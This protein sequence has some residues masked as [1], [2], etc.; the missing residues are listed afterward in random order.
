[1]KIVAVVFFLLVL[2][3]FI[4]TEKKKDS[5]PPT[6]AFLYAKELKLT[7]NYFTESSIPVK[8]NTGC[9]ERY[10]FDTM[11]LLSKNMV[12]YTDSDSL[13]IMKINYQLVFCKIDHAETIGKQVTIHFSGNGYKIIFTSKEVKK[14]RDGLFIRSGILEISKNGQK[15]L[16]YVLGKYRC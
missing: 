6:P 5:L 1:M 15:K 3:G 14:I 12:L 2:S 4:Q 8:K 10:A 16:L 13:A 7:I 11:A 9:S